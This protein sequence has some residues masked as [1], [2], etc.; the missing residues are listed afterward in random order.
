[1]T[2]GDKLII[3]NILI[4]YRVA[5]IYNLKYYILDYYIYTLLR[6][7]WQDLAAGYVDPVPSHIVKDCPILASLELVY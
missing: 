7:L 1:M 4:L 3:S 5:A 2:S 6:R